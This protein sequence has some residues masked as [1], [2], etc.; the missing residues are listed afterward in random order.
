MKGGTCL[1]KSYFADYRFSEDLDF[2]TTAFLAPDTL[3]AWVK[4]T[5]RWAVEHDGPDFTATLAR[6]EIVK[7]E[8]G[9]ESYQ[10]RV[11]FRGPLRWGCTP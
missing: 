10:V 5:V 3:M 9:S 11:Y 8:Y 2:T 1:R 6:L 4:R 7:D